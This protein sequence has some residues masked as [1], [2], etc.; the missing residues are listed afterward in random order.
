LSRNAVGLNS[1]AESVCAAVVDVVDVLS[2]SRAESGSTAQLGLECTACAPA[3]A[4]MSSFPLRLSPRWRDN[5][6]TSQGLRVQ[7]HDDRVSAITAASRRSW[8]CLR[9]GW[10]FP[11]APQ[12]REQVS[13]THVASGCMIKFG[14][15]LVWQQD[16]MDSGWAAAGYTT[17]NRFA[18][19]GVSV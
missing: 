19:I 2:E 9:G 3:R 15:W 18:H 16:G 7:L 13:D 5:P 12:L 8:F 14:D 11:K 17:S 1:G 6:P 4:A 10:F